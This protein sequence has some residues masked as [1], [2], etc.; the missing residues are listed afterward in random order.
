M[1]QSKR[2]NQTVNTQESAA[3][4][5]AGGRPQEGKAK[6]H[7]HTRE[8]NQENSIKMQEQAKEPSKWK[9]EARTHSKVQAALKR[10]NAIMTPRRAKCPH[11]EKA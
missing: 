9:G 3:R 6:T 5:K 11:T 4:A 1:K 8:A 2:C 7:T 10:N